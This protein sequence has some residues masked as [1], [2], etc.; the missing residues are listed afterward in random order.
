MNQPSAISFPVRLAPA[1]D[2]IARTVRGYED[3]L[4]E[5]LTM[6]GIGVVRLPYGFKITAA[7]GAMF[8]VEG[9]VQ[10]GPALLGY[11]D[12]DE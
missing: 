5:Q 10:V 4:M 11:L 7:S 2:P 3:R 9:L 8:L 1:L 6:R 12:S